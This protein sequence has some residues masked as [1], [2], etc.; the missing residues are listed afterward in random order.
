MSG[1]PEDFNP[2]EELKNKSEKYADLIYYGIPNIKRSEFDQPPDNALSKLTVEWMG[3][4]L[5]EMWALGKI[6]QFYIMQWALQQS[7]PA[8]PPLP[9]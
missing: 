9:N 8:P 5:W 7:D 3:T 4:P 1:Y 6:Y 2:R